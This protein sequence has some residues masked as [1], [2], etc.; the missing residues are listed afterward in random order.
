[1]DGSSSADFVIVGGGSAGSVL[2]ARLSEDPGTRVLLLEAGGEST[3]LMVQMPVGFAKMLLDAKYDWKYEQLPDP[4]INGRRFIWS[5]GRMLGGGSAINGQVYIRGTRA[6]YDAWE[7]LG[8]TGWGFDDVMPYFLRSETWHGAP[9]QNHGSHG[10]LSVSPMRDPHP[11]CGVFLDACEEM[12]LDRLDDYNG[13]EM[14]GAFLTQA[15]QLDGWRCSTEKAYLR[16]ARKRSNLEVITGA[17]VERLI[18]D[19]GRAAGVRFIRN[20]VSAE[21]RAG[22]EVLVCAG[23][24][25]SPALLMRS[26]LGPEAHLRERGIEVVKNLP[27]VGR[28]LQEHAGATQNKFVSQPTL[29]SQVGALDMIRHLA[30][31]FWNRTGPM[32]APAV[33]AMGLVRTREG[34]DEPDAQIHFMPLAYNVEP[35]TIS[36]AEAVMPKEPCVS[37]NVTLARPRSRGAVELGDGGVPV[38]RHQLLGDPA[39]LETM[40]SALKYVNR[41]FGMPALRAITLGDR[42]PEPVPSDDAGWEAYAR[43]KTMV[44]YHPVG[45]CR[46]GS[47]E[48]AV[49]DPACRVRGIGGLRVVDASVMPQITSGNTNAAT[50]MIGEKIAET[51]RRDG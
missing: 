46:M 12:G 5:A 21:A 8:A 45:S 17:H 13:G 42:S 43:A 11:L 50:I 34:L 14:E 44:A 38:I 40:V 39:D 27:Q 23:A 9:S 30:R 24:I 10:P 18:V 26:G 20:G 19:N 28:N 48:G 1:M 25:G 2:A 29:N 15:S 49:V 41:L 36:A 7:R 4:S 3:G 47:D 37:I 22:R 31:Y 16:E 33:Q 35:E 32:S 51:I 6:D